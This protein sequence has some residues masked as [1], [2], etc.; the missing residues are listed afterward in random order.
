MM[1]GVDGITIV[2]SQQSLSPHLA[3]QGTLSGNTDSPK[4]EEKLQ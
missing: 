2:L 1:K 3:E 4:Q